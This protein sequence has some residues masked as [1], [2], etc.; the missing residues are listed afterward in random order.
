[1]NFIGEPAVLSVPRGLLEKPKKEKAEFPLR[2]GRPL[3]GTFKSTF[4]H[5]I[6]AP[7]PERTAMTFPML[8][9]VAASIT[10][11]EEEPDGHRRRRHGRGGGDP[12]PQRTGL[13]LRPGDTYEAML[14]I[15]EDVE[16]A[17][18]AEERKDEVAI[19]VRLEDLHD[20]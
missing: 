9:D 16:L 4:N 12:E 18:I 15:I 3:Q 5:A 6:K 8:A 17:E 2:R 10:G 20:L 19:P 13:L 11:N 7:N 14:D 1:M